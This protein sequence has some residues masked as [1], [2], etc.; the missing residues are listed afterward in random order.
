MFFVQN[1]QLYMST[2]TEDRTAPIFAF[3]EQF[4]TTRTSSYYSI[5]NCD[6]NY[7]FVE[8]AQLKRGDEEQTAVY[9]CDKCKTI[10]Y[11]YKSAM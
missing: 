9:E 7:I 8:Q 6:H 1:N 5:K 10:K 11:D 4:P 3:H 2:A